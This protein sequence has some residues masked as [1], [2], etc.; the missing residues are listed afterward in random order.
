M[1]RERVRTL[2]KELRNS[3]LVGEFCRDAIVVGRL[4]VNRARKLEKEG[5]WALWWRPSLSFFYACSTYPLWRACNAG[6][7]L[8]PVFVGS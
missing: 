8:T 5:L 3:V 2:G 7:S 1:E 4:R 6:G